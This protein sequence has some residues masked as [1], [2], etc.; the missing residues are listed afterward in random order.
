MKVSCPWLVEI[1]VWIHI[2]GWG[3]TV[4]MPTYHPT[5]KKL[6]VI[7]CVTYHRILFQTIIYI[8][9]PFLTLSLYFKVTAATI[10]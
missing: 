9:L 6:T 5:N 3:F 4:K 8:R 7:T 10:R 2:Q 1:I